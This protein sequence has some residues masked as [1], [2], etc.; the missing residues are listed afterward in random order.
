MVTDNKNQIIM[1][2][3]LSFLFSHSIREREV[4]TKLDFDRLFE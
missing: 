1:K 3:Q 2:Y 4:N